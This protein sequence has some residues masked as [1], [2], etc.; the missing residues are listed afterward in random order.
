M[1]TKR[2]DLRKVLITD[3]YG[4]EGYFHGWG[5]FITQNENT[6]LNETKA[7]IEHE[8]GAVK[9]YDHRNIEFVN[10]D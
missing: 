8:D 6:Y 5:H 10:E 1:G 9:I 3:G 4:K 7:I 2:T